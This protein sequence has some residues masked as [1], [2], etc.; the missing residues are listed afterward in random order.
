MEK[1]HSVAVAQPKILSDR[2]PSYFEHAG[3]AGGFL[4][5]L[6]YSFC[7]GR[8][9]GE[10][11]KDAGQY[12]TDIDIFWASGAAMVVRSDLW[13]SLGGFDDSFFAHMEEIDFCWRV[14]RAGYKIKCI[15]E[16]TVYH[17]GGGTLDYADP[18]KVYLNFRNNLK[19]ILKN[20]S[21]LKLFWLFPLRLLL[22]GLA[23]IKFLFERNIPAFTSIIKAHFAVYFSIGKIFKT[24]ISNKRD[25]KATK[26][27]DLVDVRYR[28]SIVYDYYVNKKNTFNKI[29]N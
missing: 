22:D 7:R 14:N 17:Y 20:E 16:S 4:D 24:R 1:D 26:I 25:I 8:V 28:G 10:C 2:E 6:G 18:R 15:T 9:F 12:D 5:A 11:E 21:G 23:G 29:T 19:M 27:G 3:A 13:H